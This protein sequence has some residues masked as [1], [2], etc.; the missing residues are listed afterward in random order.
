MTIHIQFHSFEAIVTLHPLIC[1]AS[2]FWKFLSCI[3]IVL[4]GLLQKQ[5]NQKDFQQPV[6]I[7]LIA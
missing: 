4:K 2:R 6:S 5:L 3:R 1:L 7:S